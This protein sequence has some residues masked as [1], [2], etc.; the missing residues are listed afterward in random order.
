MRL[1]HLNCISTCPLGGHLMD[2]RADCL[3]CRGRLCCHCILAETP[4]SGLVL[5]DT[6]FGLR[7][8][9]EP[10]TRLSAFFLAMVKPELREEMTARRQIEALG[11][12][13]EDVRHIVLTHL[14]FDHAGGLDDFPQAT[15]HLMET[16]RDAALARPTWL[17]R[18]RFRPQQWSSRPRWKVYRAG[19][20][21]RWFGFARARPLEGLP[22]DIA[23]IP[24]T[25]HTLGHAGVALDGGE[26]WLLQAGDAYFYHEEMHPDAPHCTPG[27]RFYQWLMEKD[28]RARFDNQRRLRE[29]CR[30][31]AEAVEVCCGHDLTE[32]ERLAGRNAAW[33]ASARGPR[34]AAA[35]G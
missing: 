13:A 1:H 22:D 24:L 11:F 4:A 7:D 34:L 14:D 5:V 12:K 8:V 35:A 21:D 23:L 2:G 17:D 25:G 9:H 18:Q 3:L 10:R 29:L 6:G 30:D 16:E 32:F 20:G 31:H 26:R 28:R 33:P 19:G 27:L 15:V